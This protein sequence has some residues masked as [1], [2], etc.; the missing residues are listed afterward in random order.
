MIFNH[1]KDGLINDVFLGMIFVL[2]KDEFNDKN[3]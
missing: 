1:F 2:F 3:D